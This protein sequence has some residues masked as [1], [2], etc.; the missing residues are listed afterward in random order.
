MRRKPLFT[1]I[2]L[3]VVIAII[4][5]LA[6]MLLPALGMTKEKAYSISCLNNLKTIGLAQISYTMDNG[7][8]IIYAARTSSSWA[9]KT[10]SA[11][12]WGTLGGLDGNVNY[13]VSLT[14]ENGHIKAGGTF[15]CPSESVSFGDATKKEYNQA[16]YI[17]NAIGPVATT[18]G[19]TVS[20]TFNYLRKTNCVTQPGKA[21]F[22]GD[23]LPS[24]AYNTVQTGNICWLAFRHGAKDPRTT[25]S[26]LPIVPGR[27]NLLYID[28]HSNSVK[29]RELMQ[30]AN[31]NEL[32]AASMTS[33]NSSYCG[34]KRN[35]G[36]PF[37]E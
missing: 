33:D 5:V 1:L 24:L 32:R 23:S 16:K 10:Y 36:V 8:W 6:G 28:G 22:C 30:G 13:G 18:E 4:S 21:I 20:K 14:M 15:D 17:M 35:S 9:N 12:W 31:D 25:Y 3:L 26:D 19:G 7:D 29:S 27:A 34:Y 2:E 37:Y 11:S